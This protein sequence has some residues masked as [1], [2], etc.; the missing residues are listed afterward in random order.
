MTAKNSNILDILKGI[1]SF[2]RS[3]SLHKIFACVVVISLL[4]MLMSLSLPLEQTVL[5]SRWL[6]LLIVVCLLSSEFIP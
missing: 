5:I 1:L 3:L 6:V 2:V 4:A